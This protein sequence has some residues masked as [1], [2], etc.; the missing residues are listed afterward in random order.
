MKKILYLLPLGVFFGVS[1]YA[2]DEAPRADWFF[3]YSFLRYN[4]AQ[5][6]PAFTA[7]GG[8]STFAWNFNRHVAMEAELGGY[9]NG[10]VNGF[11]FDSTSFTYLFGPRLS[12][13]RQRRIDPYFHILFGGQYFTTSIA[14]DSVLIVNPLGNTTLSNGRY[15]TSQNSFSMAVGG[16]LDIRLS[17]MFTLR[18]IQADYYMTN[19]S[20][21]NVTDPLGTPIIA[22]T[23]N[24]F[25]YAAGMSF[26]FG[27]V[28]H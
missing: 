21:P 18:P 9:H 14:Q 2:Q 11:Q 26:N 15:H 6:I 28:G 4:S 27:G 25:R 16:G 7:N 19:Y 24:D 13:G 10:N 3:G 20:A 8:I 22:R 1:L 12:L 17:K 5:T 23:Q